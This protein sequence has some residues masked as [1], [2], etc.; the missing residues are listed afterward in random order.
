M[1]KCGRSYKPLIPIFF[2]PMY[3]LNLF[4]FLEQLSVVVFEFPNF[5]SLEFLTWFF[6]FGFFVAQCVSLTGFGFR[7]GSYKCVCRKGYYFPNDTSTEKWFNG[8]VLEEEYEKLMLVCIWSTR[9]GQ[10]FCLNTI[11]NVFFLS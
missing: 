11:I 1:V 4:K 10:N 6:F 3:S 2:L 9:F 7:R 5:E 8:V